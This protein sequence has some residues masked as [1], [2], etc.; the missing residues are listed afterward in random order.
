MATLNGSA[1]TSLLALLP[2]L[3]G[4]QHMSDWI[5][6]INHIDFLSSFRGLNIFLNY[7]LYVIYFKS[8]L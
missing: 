8:E 1:F 4:A 6:S 7:I 2:S 5:I 3:A